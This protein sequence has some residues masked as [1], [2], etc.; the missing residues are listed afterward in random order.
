MFLFLNF[1]RDVYNWDKGVV[2]IYN[3]NRK[4]KIL[5]QR[6]LFDDDQYSSILFKL[7]LNLFCVPRL[8]VKNVDNNNVKD[9]LLIYLDQIFLRE[10]IKFNIIKSL[11]RDRDDLRVYIKFFHN[12]KVLIIVD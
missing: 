3:I 11:F 7:I 5:T 1:F 2:K 6:L 12:N 9:V 10:H 8:I 4:S